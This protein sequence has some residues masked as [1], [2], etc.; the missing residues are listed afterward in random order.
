MDFTIAAYFKLIQ[1][2]K[3]RGYSF[4]PVSEAGCNFKDGAIILRHDVDRLPFNSLEFAKIQSAFGLKGTFYFRIVKDSFNESI[5]SQIARLG[6]EIGYHYE[7]IDLVLQRHRAKRHSV[8]GKGLIESELASLAMESFIENL[9]RFRKIAPI[10]T[11]CMHGS[12][13]SRIENRVL[14]KY[15]DYK[16]YGVDF[17]P[18]FDLDF[19]NKLYL[20]DTGRSWRGSSVSV[21]DKAFIISN[22]LSI[23]ERYQEWLLKPTVGSLMNMTSE[24]VAFQKRYK[25]RSTEAIIKDVGDSL[26]PNRAMITFHPQR[27]NEKR[28]PWLKELL[29][30]SVKN[31]GK[32]FL[33]KLRS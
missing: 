10:S 4:L 18:Y 33:I 27:W 1:C 20:T 17:E 5:I 8:R 30:Q 15:Y 9:V 13:L 7:D 6:H 3:E 2:L 21:R 24:G 23:D 22:Q 32:Y 12:P 14:W 25:Y 16:K 28:L 26:F 11:I 19:T 29:Y 31:A